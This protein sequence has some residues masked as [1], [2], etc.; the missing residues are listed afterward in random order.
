MTRVIAADD[1][2]RL[3]HRETLP[4]FFKELIQEL[5]MD[6]IRWDEFE[7]SP[8]H[9]TYV[10]DGVIELMPIADKEYYAY[11]YVNGHP[12]NPLQHKQTVIG[13]GQLSLIS[14]GYP[15]LIAEMTL[16]TALRTAATSALC[17]LYMAP[18]KAKN[19]GIIGTGAQSEFQALAHYFALGLEEIYYYDTDASAME[20]FAKNLLPFSLRL[21]PCKAAREVVEKSDLITTATARK[22]HHKVIESSWIQKGCHIN[23]IGGD[24]PGKTEMDAALLERAKIVVELLE[25]SKIE[26]EIQ[27]LQKPLIYAAL[28][29]LASGAKKGRTADDEIT[30]FDSVGFALEDYS[31]LKLVHRLAEE[32][33]IGH[34]LE[35]V[36]NI[37]NPKDL[38]A[39]LQYEI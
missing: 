16:L 13:I 26:G 37:P 36:P 25:Q 2:M 34:Q 4:R 27:Q 14:T 33:N 5:K 15:I 23:K 7:K 21:H 19:F 17:S 24:C 32:Y 6:F 38:F 8:R 28:W 20:K 12:K 30:L 3:I 39:A 11:K 22:G 1:V 18:K 31:V 35:M 29:E 10:L 9:A